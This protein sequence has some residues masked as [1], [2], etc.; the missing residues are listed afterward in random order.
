MKH[1]MID[2]YGCDPQ[3]LA[4]ASLLQYV[5]DEYPNRDR[6]AEGEPCLLKR[7]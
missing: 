3:L 6:N 4:D 2:L 1:V 5:L 7:H